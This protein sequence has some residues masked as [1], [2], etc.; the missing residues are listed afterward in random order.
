MPDDS[1]PVHIVQ[2]PVQPTT[3]GRRVGTVFDWAW[4]STAF[5]G[6]A[7]TVGMAAMGGMWLYDSGWLARIETMIPKPPAPVPVSIAIRGPQPRQVLA[8]VST[9]L[10]ADTSGPAGEP[11]W[12]IIPASAG[13]LH[14][15]SG[16]VVEFTANIDGE[17]AIHV[18]VAGSG[19]QLA[20]AQIEV[21]ALGQQ[22]ANMPPPVDPSIPPPAPPQPQQEVRSVAQQTQLFLAQVNSANKVAEAHTVASAIAMV[23]GLINSGTVPP[24]GNVGAMVE[25]TALTALGQH[26]AA[27][28]G[29]L[30]GV[31]L[32]LDTLRN[33]GEIST[34]ATTVPVLLEISGVLSQAR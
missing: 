14:P 6:I 7:V 8:N 27:W 1:L 21:E 5:F 11:Q 31:S 3:I 19:N 18:A 30:T 16:R 20:Q 17:V 25:D 9:M 4:H 13:R 12:A 22:P 24:T 2:P 32:I 29:F 34:A 28:H 23:V 33:Q 10:V 15:V 26:G